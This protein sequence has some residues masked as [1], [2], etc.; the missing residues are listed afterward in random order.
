MMFIRVTRSAAVS[1]FAAGLE[2]RIDATGEI[3]QLGKPYG[4]SKRACHRMLSRWSRCFNGN[5]Q[6][7][8]TTFSVLI[9][10]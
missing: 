3:L 6:P 1:A 5:D 8:Q 7:I 9:R 10:D 2:V 4:M